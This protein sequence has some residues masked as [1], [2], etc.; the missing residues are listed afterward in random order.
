MCFWVY[1]YRGLKGLFVFPLIALWLVPLKHVWNIV[2]LT[3]FTKLLNRASCADPEFE[4]QAVEKLA[5]AS[6][7]QV[8]SISVP[9]P[10][11]SIRLADGYGG[12]L[13][14]RPRQAPGALEQ[15]CSWEKEQEQQHRSKW[16]IPRA[17]THRGK[18]SRGGLS[19]PQPGLTHTAQSES[20]LQMWLLIR[21]NF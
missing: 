19:P 5:I 4:T 16:L 17:D 21:A 8:G 6:A 2:I 15:R 18:M 14:A 11:M 10:C 20:R 7:W 1:V 12:W 3:F 9:S 13:C